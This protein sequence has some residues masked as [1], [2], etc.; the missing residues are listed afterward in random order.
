MTATIVVDHRT[1]M[2][3]PS[4]AIVQDPQTGQT[5]VFMQNKD[6]SFASRTVTVRGSDDKTGLIT[7]GV[8]PG[9]RVATQGSYQ[10]L[11]PNGG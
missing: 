6:G 3:V 8:H 2:L 11:A 4:S 5:V 10:L 9:E 7:S 1:G